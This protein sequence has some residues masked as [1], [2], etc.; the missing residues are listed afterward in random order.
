MTTTMPPS[1]PTWLVRL[2]AHCTVQEQR[3]VDRY[4]DSLRCGFDAVRAGEH[5]YQ[6]LLIH[7]HRILETLED[8]AT[9]TP[10]F[11]YYCQRQRERLNKAKTRRTVDAAA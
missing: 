6:Q 3:G 7:W 2:L 10:G 4:R 1:S 11:D 9:G 5:T 8:S